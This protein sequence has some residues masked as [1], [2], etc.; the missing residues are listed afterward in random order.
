MG[1]KRNP[2][3][4][5]KGPIRTPICG[6]VD[7]IKM[8]VKYVSREVEMRI[9]LSQVRVQSWSLVNMVIRCRVPQKLSN[10]L[11][12]Y[13]AIRFSRTTLFLVDGSRN[14]IFHILTTF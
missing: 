7:N 13:A 14:L 6:Q 8:G 1:V 4:K 12:G 10:Y 9:H 11:D 2:K 5:E 3:Y